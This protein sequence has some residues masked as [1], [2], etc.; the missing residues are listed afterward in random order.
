MLPSLLRANPRSRDRRNNSRSGSQTQVLGF[1]SFIRLPLPPCNYL[2]VGYKINPFASLPPSNCSQI[3]IIV[4]T[5]FAMTSPFVLP[6]SNLSH[7]MVINPNIDTLASVPLANGSSDLLF[8]MFGHGSA[9]DFNALLVYAQESLD[10]SITN[11]CRTW[12]V[13]HSDGAV[14]RFSSNISQLLNMVRV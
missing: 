11:S 14:W 5:T 7:F 4:N 10:V 8:A 3:S 12:I 1:H 9:T 13:L 6:S 2:P